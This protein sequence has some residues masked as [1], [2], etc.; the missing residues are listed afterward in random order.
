MSIPVL[1]SRPPEKGTSVV[2]SGIEIKERKIFSLRLGFPFRCQTEEPFFLAVPGGEESESD[3]IDSKLFREDDSGVQR[4]S[5]TSVEERSHFFAPF[6]FTEKNRGFPFVPELSV[7]LKGAF[8]GWKPKVSFVQKTVVFSPFGILPAL[9]AGRAWYIGMAGKFQQ[10][11]PTGEEFSVGFRRVAFISG[12]FFLR[13]SKQC[14]D[15]FLDLRSDEE[16]DAAYGIFENAEMTFPSAPLAVERKE[17]FFHEGCRRGV[18]PSAPVPDYVLFPLLRIL[19]QPCIE[20]NPEPVAE[21]SDTDV[22][23][24]AHGKFYSR[25]QQGTFQSNG[26]GGGIR[27]QW[28]DWNERSVLHENINFVSIMIYG[29]AA[30][31]PAIHGRENLPTQGRVVLKSVNVAVAVRGVFRGRS[32]PRRIFR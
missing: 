11:T 13:F 7:A 25:H 23:T 3:R 15:F 29:N 24:V 18:T 9:P 4:S 12:H 26:H 5:F 32:V 19:H 10:G 31:L 17:I 2:I 28:R 16:R 8:R 14:T 1:R 30:C 27:D 22:R 21:N 6:L 20:I